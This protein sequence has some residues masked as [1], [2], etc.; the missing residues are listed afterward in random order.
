MLAGGHYEQMIRGMKAGVQTKNRHGNR[1]NDSNDRCLN[2]YY[3]SDEIVAAVEEL[4]IGLKNVQ[5]LS[6]PTVGEEVELSAYEYSPQIVDGEFLSLGIQ[7]EE[8]GLEQL[9][10]EGKI[11]K[12]G[13]EDIAAIKAAGYSFIDGVSPQEYRDPFRYGGMRVYLMLRQ[14]VKMPAGLAGADRVILMIPEDLKMPDNNGGHSDYYNVSGTADQW[15]A[16][17]IGGQK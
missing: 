12:V 3:G 10:E 2:Y 15:Q 1:M 17:E 9:I 6:Q 5:V 8:A 11:R 7:P 14:F 16:Q 4:N 13:K